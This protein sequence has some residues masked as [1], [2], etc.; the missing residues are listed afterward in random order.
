MITLE[1]EYNDMSNFSRLDDL[2][3]IRD[4]FRIILDMFGKINTKKL[5][6]IG[7]AYVIVRAP[8]VYGF[9]SKY[10][11][12]LNYFSLYFVNFYMDERGYKYP[13]SKYEFT[14][15]P[16]SSRQY[17]GPQRIEKNRLAMSRVKPLI[18]LARINGIRPLFTATQRLVTNVTAEIKRIK[19]MEVR[20]ADARKRELKLQVDR[21]EALMREA[22]TVELMRK[23]QEEQAKLIADV[24]AARA[25]EVQRSVEI[26]AARDR[27]A[28]LL[29]DIADARAREATKAKLLV[30]AVQFQLSVDKN[31]LRRQ[32]AI[33]GKAKVIAKQTAILAN[34][35]ERAEFIEDLKISKAENTAMIQD[36]ARSGRTLEDQLQTSKEIIFGING[37]ISKLAYKKINSKLD[38]LKVIDEIKAADKQVVGTFGEDIFEKN[39]KGWV[40]S[41]RIMA[42]NLPDPEVQKEIDQEIQIVAPKKAGLGIPII[43]V[44]LAAAYTT[45]K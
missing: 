6:R 3:R 9:L 34:K 2:N 42:L 25:R 13:T 35:E 11:L 22:K 45:F 26:Q 32:V 8:E 17:G 16:Y 40:E 23:S 30:N 37:M 15:T 10:K 44:G 41:L 29:S 1:Q 14:L 21:N 7:M 31:K 19:E 39:R 43:I 27:E 38:L 24:A 36:A 20:A 18:I 28:K 12:K 4:G 5:N 33:A